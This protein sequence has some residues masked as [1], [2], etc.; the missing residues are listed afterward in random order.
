MFELLPKTRILK[1]KNAYAIRY[2]TAACWVIGSAGL[3][4]AIVLVPS[5]YVAWLRVDSIDKAVGQID[6]ARVRDDSRVY[7]GTV[8]VV[9]AVAAVASSS[10]PHPDI[11]LDALD[12]SVGRIRVQE[13]DLVLSKDDSA[14]VLTVI[15]IAPTRSEAVSFAERLGDTGVFVDVDVPIASL[16]KEFDVPFTLTAR[17][18][19]SALITNTP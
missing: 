8:R 18:P 10:V 9:S 2:A 3:A 15:G 19:V 12:S 13:Y 14:Y 11:I 1:A 7:G 5:T 17:V 6:D 16:V 4:W